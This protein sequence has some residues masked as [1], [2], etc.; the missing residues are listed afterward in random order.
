MASLDDQDLTLYLVYDHIIRMGMKQL[1]QHIFKLGISAGLD[2]TNVKCDFS[3]GEVVKAFELEWKND[4]KDL[5]DRLV[6]NYLRK[7]NPCEVADQLVRVCNL[8][9]M[10]PLMLDH[11]TWVESIYGWM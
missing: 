6:C 3:I 10:D 2:L 9:E 8:R 4:T 7:T 5:L 11:E 1:G